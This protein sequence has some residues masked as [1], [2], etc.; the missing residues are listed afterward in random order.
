MMVGCSKTE[1]TITRTL[2]R[3]GGIDYAS[4]KDIVDNYTQDYI[5]S[6]DSRTNIYFDSDPEG[7]ERRLDNSGNSTMRIGFFYKFKP[8]EKYSNAEIDLCE[9]GIRK[10]TPNTNLVGVG[11]VKQNGIYKYYFPLE[12]LKNE[13]I[14]SEEKENQKD[15]CF[16]VRPS[17]Y[18]NISTVTHYKSNTITY[19]AEEINQFL[20]TYNLR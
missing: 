7:I 4:V 14:I 2:E 19:T 17:T 5:N 20:D 16:Y 15:I 18:D 8:I 9:N 1:E 6:S 11:Q 13:K 10:V 12:L 3:V